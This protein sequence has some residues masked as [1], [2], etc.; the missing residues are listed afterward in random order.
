MRIIV[1]ILSLWVLGTLSEVK[2]CNVDTYKV[3]RVP[4]TYKGHTKIRY[5]TA[6]TNCGDTIKI[7]EYADQ[8]RNKKTR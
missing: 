6:V 4:C 5:G 7:Y 8:I 3:E 2:K 1:S